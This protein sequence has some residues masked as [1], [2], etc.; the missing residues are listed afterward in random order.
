MFRRTMTLLVSILLLVAALLYLSPYAATLRME[1]AIRE[2]DAAT[3]STYIDFPDLRESVKGKAGAVLGREGPGERD[4]LFAPFLLLLTAT[5][6]NLTVDALVTPEGL[7]LWLRYWTPA[8]AEK[9]ETSKGYEAYGR[10]AVRV[11]EKGQPENEI[12]FVFRREEVVSWKL[13]EVRFPRW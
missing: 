5:L 8:R 13:Y 4:D 10:F 2:R 6:T 7:D 12:V 9:V 3:L 1:R 11:R